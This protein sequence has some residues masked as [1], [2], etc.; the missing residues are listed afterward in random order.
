MSGCGSPWWRCSNSKCARPDAVAA[1][2]ARFAAVATLLYCG[3][4][5]LVLVWLWRGEWFDAYDAAAVAGRVCD[6]RNRPASSSHGGCR[7]G[8]SL[9]CFMLNSARKG[10]VNS[11][12]EA[13]EIRLRQPVDPRRRLPAAAGL[14]LQAQRVRAARVARAARARSPRSRRAG[15]PAAHGRAAGAG[16]R[17]GWRRN[18]GCAGSTPRPAARRAPR[19][20]LAA[21]GAIAPARVEIVGERALQHLEY[22][23]ALDEIARI[24]VAA[25]RL[26]QVRGMVVQ[27]VHGLAV[28]VVVDGLAEFAQ[29]LEVAARRV[30][31]P[32]PR[33]APARRGCRRRPPPPPTAAGARSR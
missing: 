27:V 9:V 16:A 11:R 29:A 17:A 30:R 3:L 15:S 1:H 19:A 31:A 24:G 5:A 7:H 26:E 18:R 8:A 13:R 25:H 10:L 21:C 2:R 28:G 32:P 23:L 4:V 6:D 14:E 22:R 33:A 12:D 20:P